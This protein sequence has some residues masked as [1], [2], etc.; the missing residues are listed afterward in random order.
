LEQV[1]DIIEGKRVLGHPREIQ[2]VHNALAAY[3]L[4]ESLVAHSSEDFLKAHAALMMALADD[5]GRFRTG[6][7]GVYQGERV[8]HM[9]PPA[10]R[11]PHLVSDLFDWLHDTDLHP[12]LASA[13]VHYEIEFIHP[14][15][16]GNGRIG[17]LWQTVV[18]AKWKPQLAFLPV[19][20]VVHDR[21]AAYYKALATSDQQADVAPFAEFILQAMLEAMI[22]Q[23]W[24]DH[25]S[26]QASD[27]V[28]LLLGVLKPRQTSS[29]TE[30][31]QLLE[32]KHRPTFRNNYLNPALV[33][34]FIEKTDPGSP[35]SPTQR[36]RL[37]RKGHLV[38]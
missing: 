34:G 18:L 26:D 13:A 8:V 7:V 3:Q 35:R 2:E 19:E 38:M 17:R 32:L 21:Q 29:A 15:S 30:L 5:A 10:E 16:D 27:Q 1:T 12:L 36:Y 37:T 14:F 22:A 4:M 20:T 11:V 9:A 33:L 6:G 24:S 25:V 28:R 31:M 23:P